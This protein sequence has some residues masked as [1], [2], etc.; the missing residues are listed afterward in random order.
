MNK[1][2]NILVNLN[3]IIFSKYYERRKYDYGKPN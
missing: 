2:T 3:V 1:Y